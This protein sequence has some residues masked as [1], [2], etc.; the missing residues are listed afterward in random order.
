MGILLG[1]DYY[2]EQWPEEMWEQDADHMKECGVKLVRMAEFAW[3]RLEPEEGDFRFEWLDHAVSVFKD[4]GIQIFLCTP[5][6]TPPLWA[7]EK[8][9]EII[10]VGTDGRRISIGIRGHR[11]MN[12]P[13]YRTLCERIIRQLVDHYRDEEA[14]IGYQIDNELEANHCRCAVC[15]EAFRDWMKEKYGTTEQIN[16]AYG[17]SVWSGEYSSFSQVKPPMGDFIKW[18][19][20]SLTLDY[21]RYASDSTVAY[22][23]FQRKLIHSLDPKAQI[24][25]NSWLCENMPDFYDL[26][27]NLDFVSYDNYPTTMIP[28]DSQELYSHAFHL[29][30]MRGILQKNFWIMEQLS[31]AVGSWM[32]MSA[33][34]VP[35]M[36]KGYA[37]QAAAHGADAVIHFRWRT[38]VSGAEM[39]WHGIL[40]H[41]NV[42]GRRYQ[43]FKELGQTIKQLQELDGSEVVNRVALLYSS[44]NEYGFKLQ[45]QAEG[46]YYLEQLKCLHDGFTGIGVGVDIIDERASFDGYDIVLAPTMLIE[47]SGTV[48]KLENF[49]KQG[50]TVLLTNRSGVKNLSNQCIMDSLPTIY[51]ELAGVHVTEYNAAGARTGKLRITDAQLRGQ[52]GQICTN[53]FLREDASSLQTEHQDATYKRWCDILEADTAEVLAV[54][55][56]Q[57]YAGQPAVT[58]NTYGKGRIYYVGTVLDRAFYMALAARMAQEQKLSFRDDLPLGVEITYRQKQDTTWRF[59]FNNSDKPQSIS[60]EGNICSLKPF[61]MKID[62]ICAK[63]KRI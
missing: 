8:Y 50:G 4:R 9:P 52:Y 12:S 15:E 43:E 63:G 42:P 21:N 31:G 25:T 46:M 34:P 51:K 61:E 57:Y 13:V 54:Y 38:A 1:V 20:P 11:C 7:F 47:H 41:S 17:N 62:K 22:L 33:M 16:Q 44:D 36:I 24:T 19:N 28:T 23:E 18:Q 32:P 3:S 53:S 49:A 48:K 39:Y 60:L 55:G 56:D 45:H 40:D 26:F 29:D 6:C 37:L 30:L 35:G 5:T 59:V 58:V 14:V 2:P 27:H 10:Q